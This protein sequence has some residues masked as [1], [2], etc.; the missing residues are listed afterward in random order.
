[1]DYFITILVACSTFGIFTFIVGCFYSESNY[2]PDKCDCKDVNECEKW[3]IGKQNYT[4]FHSYSIKEECKHPN[5][6]IRIL[7]SS[8]TC[9]TTIE[10]CLDCY[11][12]LTEPKTDC[13]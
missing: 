2:N 9:E 3:C 10:V 6:A 5:R 13:R 12:E 8:T 7:E 1:M 4:K 11:Q